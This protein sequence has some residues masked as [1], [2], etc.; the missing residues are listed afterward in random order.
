MV[1]LW[2]LF[3]IIV[4]FSLLFD[5]GVVTEKAGGKPEVKQIYNVSGAVLM[6]LFWIIVAISFGISLYYSYGGKT[7]MEYFSC[8][9]LEKGLSIDNVFVFHLVFRHFQVPLRLEK[10]VLQWGIL[11]ALVMRALFIALGI[12]LLKTFHFLIF[13]LGGF[14]VVMGFSLFKETFRSDPSAN[15]EKTDNADNLDSKKHFYGKNFIL[16]FV[17]RTLPYT[18]AFFDERF[19]IRAPT[20]VNEAILP[21]QVIPLGVK[22]EKPQVFDLQPEETLKG[23]VPGRFYATKLLLALIC[24]EIMDA[25]FALDSIPAI[26]SLTDDPLVMYTSNIFAILGLRALFFAVSG[27][28]YKFGYLQYGLS[29]LLVF[30][31]CKML[32]SRAVKV[33]LG[34]SLIVII[35]VISTSILASVLQQRREKRAES[36]V[37]SL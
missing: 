5:V 11:G 13:I 24:V 30:V 28:V 22:N 29:V 16:Q 14:L 27:M 34:L 7:A 9:L 8:Y 19:V 21:T 4:L 2:V 3:A 10:I 15:K 31:G 26:L 36:I 20:T 12:Q 23:L 18:D 1:I 35:V 17:M 6:S 37:V 25:L 33:P 32:A